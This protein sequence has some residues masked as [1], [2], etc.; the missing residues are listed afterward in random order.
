MNFLS[1]KV[2]YSYESIVKNFLF[3]YLFALSTT[4]NILNFEG[5][6]F[7]LLGVSVVL[8]LFLVF[9]NYRHLP[10]VFQ[11]LVLILLFY[12][13]ISFLI[14]RESA[15]VTSFLYS[16]FYLIS[17]LFLGG[18][19]VKFLDQED[20]VKIISFI[21]IAYFIVTIIGQ[22]Y[23]FL[24]FFHAY[25]E[26]VNLHS[27]FGT[28]F[29]RDNNAIRFYS[30]STEPSY[31]SIV[32][33]CLYYVYL[34]VGQ[35]IGHG[36]NK[37]LISIIVF[38]MILVFNSG[39]G[40]LLL[41]ILLWTLLSKQKPHWAVFGF[42]TLVLLF[43]ILLFVD[44]DINALNRIKGILTN[45]NFSDWTSIKSIDYSASFRVLPFYY[46]IKTSDLTS[47]NFYLG[48]GAG[49]SDTILNP[50]LFP[51]ATEA[52]IFHGGF[53]PGFL[54]DYGFLGFI[55]FAVAFL[56]E[57]QALFSFGIIIMLFTLTN[58]NFN[59]QLFWLVITFLYMERKIKT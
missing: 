44:I 23:V 22:L 41:A 7:F 1:L 40:F 20:L 9:I 39:Y 21:L 43:G 30:L 45:F 4:F 54:I 33:V 55:V 28:A 10:N 17:F 26:G 24:G 29:S 48:Y 27:N 19:C 38:Y 49:T 47:I 50:Y 3:L 15:S 42:V 59:T 12:M 34:Q 2:V 52:V 13:T 25:G 16:V 32:V 56:K 53:L 57:T 18:F 46:F 35:R 31:S 8:C 58:A 11:N 51:N 5:R 6:N 37:M 36:R 14:N